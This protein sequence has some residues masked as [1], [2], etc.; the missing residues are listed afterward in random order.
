MAFILL[1]R[2]LITCLQFFGNASGSGHTGKH[3]V[4]V[5]LHRFVNLK[6]MGI[7]LSGQEQIAVPAG[8]VLLQVPFPHT[9]IDADLFVRLLA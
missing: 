9:A 2:H 5:A 3:G 1:P 7:Q 8:V 6:Q 4:Q